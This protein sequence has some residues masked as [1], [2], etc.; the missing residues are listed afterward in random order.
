MKDSSAQEPICYGMIGIGGFGRERRRQLRESGLFRLKGGVD[1]R[2]EAFE[3]AEQAEGHPIQQY[4]SIEQLANDP[5]IE[6]VVI[7]TPA[8]LHVEQATM[9]ARA[10]KAI[11]TEKPLGHDL[12]ACRELVEYCERHN[13]PHGHGFSNYFSP[14][15]QL[16][17]RE[18][19]E[20]KLLGQL[21][22]ISMASMHTGGLVSPETNWRFRSDQNP[23]GPLY[24]CGIHYL[25]L[26]NVLFGG[27]KWLHGVPVHGISGKPVLDGLV[28]TGMFGGVPVTF[29]SHYV[30]SY[31]H[32]WEFYGTDGNLLVSEHPERL[33]YK[34]A[35]RDSGFEP[36]YDWTDKIAAEPPGFHEQMRDLAEAVRERRQPIINGRH[37]LEAIASI[38]QALE[39][40]EKAD[41]DSVANKSMA[42]ST[43]C[44]SQVLS[45]L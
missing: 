35:I 6:L 23:G 43:A 28:L 22:S 39:V 38:Y 8:H 40:S 9:A 25:H 41:V 12:D 42:G 37:G 24:Q 2:Q 27:G 21:V 30:A 7:S 16:V 10:G 20:N 45:H 34:K 15:W 14:L 33:Q 29:H 17:R 18:I 31:W 36:I 4:E 26:L 11:F 32:S 44:G 5:E 3:E 13:I 1:L 19:F